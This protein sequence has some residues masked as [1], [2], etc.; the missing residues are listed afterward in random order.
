MPVNRR[1]VRKKSSRTNKKRRRADECKITA[2]AG[3]AVRESIGAGMKNMKRASHAPR[4]FSA[5]GGVRKNGATKRSASAPVF[6]HPKTELEAA[7]QR[8]VDLFELAPIGYVT[9]DHVGRIEEINVAAAQLLGGSRARLIGQP[10][11]LYVTKDDGL[12]FLNHLLRCRSSDRRVETELHLKKRNG[13]IILTR[14]ESSPMTSSMRDGARLYQTAIVDL[15]ERKRFEEK[16][17]RSEERYRTLFDLVPVAIY[18]CD[19]DGIIREYNRRAVE[20]WGREPTGNG[21]E[22]RFCGSYKIYYPDG[23][24]MPHDEC[25]MARA[26]R[27]EK[28]TPKD[29]EIVIERPDGERRHVVPAPRVLAD[30]QGKITGAV[31]CLF[32]ITERK[33]AETAAMR[34]AAAVQSSHD[35]IAAKTLNGIITDWNQS[36]ERIFGYKPKEIIGKSVLTLIPK[37]RQD[38]EQEILRRI[39]RGESL[40]HYETVRR[41]KDGQLI[42]VSLTIS[43]IKG[44]KGEIFG[45]S[46]IARDI[47]NQ[48][49]TERRLAE[50]A[51][52]LDLTNDAV[53][54]RDHH[55]RIVYWNRGAEQMYGFPAKE[56]LGKITHELLQTAYPENLE[57]IRKNLA[58]DNRWSGELVHTRKDGAKVVVISRWSL[59]RGAKGQP[60]S[61]LE[62]NTEI[63]DRKR[64]EQ[65]TAVNLAVAR[66]LSESPALTQAVPGILQAVCENL[67][68]EVGAF[69]MPVPGGKVL[70]CLK[71]FESAVDKF[72]KFKA[73]SMKLRLAP[74][75][76][77]PGRV[78]KN[79]KTAWVPDITKDRNFPRAA[80]AAKEGV[81]GTFAFPISFGKQFLGVMEFFSPEIREPDEDLLKMFASIGSQIGQFVQ[82][83]QTEEALQRSKE[84]LEKRVRERTRELD[85]A[86]KGLEGE[87]ERRKGLEGEILAVSDREQQRLGQELHDGLCQHLTAV[88]FMAR[89]IA[90]RLRNHRVIDAND[91]EKIAELVNDAAADTREL[92]RALHRADVDA[93][94]MVTALQDLVDRE[95]WKTP[96]RLQVRP[97]FHIDDN[98][99]A[100]H[101]Y[102]IARE[103]VINA[104]KHAQA[105]QI[106]IKL[107]RSRLGMV[108]RVI[109][110][111]VGFSTDSKLKRGMGFHIMNY[112]AQ[113]I[114]GRLK[115]ERPQKG[116]T[117]V[118]CYLADGA[119]QPPKPRTKKNG[120]QRTF[121]G[122]ITKAL[123]ALV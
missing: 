105:R 122:K 110:D 96:C 49:Q 81:H 46:K 119:S 37:D 71:V 121:A 99:A 54:V 8:Y 80:V 18:V 116:G 113:L 82:R 12:L 66:I 30:G 25:P 103:A 10:F 107:E 36:A 56:A 93:A 19:A 97:S 90:M 112:R 43:P 78:W 79:L 59:D 23:R 6:K 74:G 83:K 33:R 114:G 94:G 40:D 26:L 3:G 24:Q 27:G 17:Q 73:A 62:T 38:E 9:F 45:V 95:I 42:D 55:D 16:I 102:R 35:A 28:L 2:S 63:T 21:E 7:T 48:K 100:A 47:T 85:A 117:C 120:Q 20:L 75:I 106:V 72:P 31:N 58:R 39:R 65:Q 5:N 32:D 29:L 61:I 86:N 67:G 13:D 91:I 123:A 76:G 104:N 108:L 14:L 69:W 4:K 109:D 88:A 77:L 92:S 41:R 84:L 115:I 64:S 11:A 87:I 22:P 118:S 68:W 51:R 98:I 101:L 89:S 57:K 1:T 60:A 52:L 70:R 34:L 53:I 111:G 15:T 50:Q 44:P